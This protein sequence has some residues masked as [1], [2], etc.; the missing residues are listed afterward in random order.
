M[1]A[2]LEL[3]KLEGQ[4]LTS[5]LLN[6]VLEKGDCQREFYIELIKNFSNFWRTIPDWY[7]KKLGYDWKSEPEY[8]EFIISNLEATAPLIIG[9]GQVSVLETHMTLHRILGVPYIPGTALKG[10][11]AHYC[12]KY[13]GEV[14]P[15]FRAGGEY[16]T[17]LFGSQE[18]AGFIHYYDA[19]PTVETVAC[20]LILDVLTPHHQEYNQIRLIDGQGQENAPAPRD[21]DSPTPVYFL[22]ARA[23]FKVMLTCEN[24]QQEGKD[25]LAIAEA[26]LVQAIKQEGIGGKTNSGYGIFELKA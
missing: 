12:N 26:V 7:A 11:S 14:N 8:R 16:Y 17:I 10:I 19:F 21:D 13:L 4:K 1:N 24:D 15:E 18:Q 9:N 2:F 25:W 23:D 6:V 3:T 22:T 20:S 5:S